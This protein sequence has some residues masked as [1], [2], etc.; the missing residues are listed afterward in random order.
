MEDNYCNIYSGLKC[1][2]TCEG[3]ENDGKGPKDGNGRY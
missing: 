3:Y 2:L 1:N